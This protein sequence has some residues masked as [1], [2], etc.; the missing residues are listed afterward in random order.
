LKAEH[1][2]ADDMRMARLLGQIESVLMEMQRLTEEH[3]MAGSRHVASLI[4]E[5]GLLTTI[6]RLKVGVED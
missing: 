1:K 6:Q 3:D 4:E 5:Q 2:T